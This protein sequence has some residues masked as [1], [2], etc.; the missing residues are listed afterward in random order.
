MISEKISTMTSTKILADKIN[1]LFDKQGV[2]TMD[3]ESLIDK[4]NSLS[5][6]AMLGLL[7]ALSNK[8]MYR[9]VNIL[10]MKISK[11]KGISGE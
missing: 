2:M 8:E 11:T 4:I 9:I 10:G 6:N 1:K 3:E 7:E 5:D